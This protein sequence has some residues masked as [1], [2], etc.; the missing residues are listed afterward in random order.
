MA[1]IEEDTRNLD[2]GSYVREYL[3]WRYFLNKYTLKPKPLGSLLM[4]PALFL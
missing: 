2:E 4:T 3:F 1:V